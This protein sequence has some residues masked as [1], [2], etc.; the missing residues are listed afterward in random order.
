MRAR[1]IMGPLGSPSA[2][3]GDSLT[4]QKC[5]GRRPE[6]LCWHRISDR[7][8]GRFSFLTIRGCDGGTLLQ[9]NAAF[10]GVCCAHFCAG[11]VSM[12]GESSAM[13]RDIDVLTS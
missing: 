9:V 3:A 1:S 11:L 6:P 8:L 4:A 5:T 2:A 12:F 7:A 13:I 10:C